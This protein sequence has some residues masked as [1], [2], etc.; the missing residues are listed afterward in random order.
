[1]EVRGTEEG[2][3]VG[4][5]WTKVWQLDALPKLKHFVWRMG[6]GVL[7]TRAAIPRRGMEIESECGLSGHD[8]E[9]MEHV[10][11]DC[12]ITHT[13]WTEAGLV[14]EVQSV[15][16]RHESMAAWVFQAIRVIPKD[17][18]LGVFSLMWSIWAERNKRVW[19][20]ESRTEAVIVKAGKKLI[21]D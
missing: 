20:R 4:G 6:R 13:C 2:L 18:Q 10:F 14:Q 5:D 21:D 1:M 8:E 16:L 17:A 7:S 15:G 19:D 3:R 9:T 11:F 12:L